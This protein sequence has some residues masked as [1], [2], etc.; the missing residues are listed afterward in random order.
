MNQSAR[1][2]ANVWG[3][4]MVIAKRTQW[5]SNLETGG[6]ESSGLETGGLKSNSWKRVFE[7]S[8]VATESRLQQG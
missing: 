1:A 5:I 7:A 3:R 4:S 6:L 2:A 8:L